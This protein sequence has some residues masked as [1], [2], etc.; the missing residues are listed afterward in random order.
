[1][2]CL[3]FSSANSGSMRFACEPTLSIRQTFVPVGIAVDVVPAG[4][5]VAGGEGGREQHAVG[6]FDRHQVFA[7][8]KGGRAVVGQVVVELVQVGH[9]SDSCRERDCGTERLV[10]LLAGAIPVLE[11]VA[12]RTAETEFAGR[13]PAAAVRAAAGSA[14]V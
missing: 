6:P 5:V 12:A 7:D 1:M 14:Q 11:P 4:E 10:F 8:D 2:R 3:Y 13:R 9:R